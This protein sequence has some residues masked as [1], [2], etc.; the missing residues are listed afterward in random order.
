[1]DGVDTSDPAIEDT[2]SASLLPIVEHTTMALQPCRECGH[3]VSTEASELHALRLR[4]VDQLGG[5]TR[6]PVDIA[7]R[8][9]H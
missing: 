8:K 5:F 2:D 9:L 1:M 4:Q 7:T 3:E 6:Y